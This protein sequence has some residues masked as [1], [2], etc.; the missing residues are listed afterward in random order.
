MRLVSFLHS[1][2]PRLGVRLGDVLVDLHAVNPRLPRDMAS[3][4][5]GGEDALAAVA[6]ALRT[7]PAE[8][9]MRFSAVRLLP[10]VPHPGKIIC[11]GL[12]YVDHAVEIDPRNLPDYP[13]FFGRLAS[14]LVAHNEPLLRPSVSTKLDFEGEVAVVIG[15]SGRM[16]DPGKALGHVGGYALFNEGSVRDY[17]FR[18]SQWFLGK[19]FDATGAFGPE[20]CTPDELPP[21]AKG[22]FLATRVNGRVM[23][24][25]TTS[26]MLF[27]VATLIASL[28]EAMTLHPGDVIVTGTPSGVGFAQKPPYY[29]KPGDVCEIEL[30]GYGVLRNPVTD[31]PVP[32]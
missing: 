32:F 1:D 8:S 2:G 3:F 4:L 21:G 17:Q 6:A 12:N 31:A 19:N 28:S 22:L 7:A 18:T 30:E 11:V 13:T 24:E 20:L 15:K 10:P 16:I 23:Q 29:L 26:E 27:G 25:A 9:Q 14:T 5:A